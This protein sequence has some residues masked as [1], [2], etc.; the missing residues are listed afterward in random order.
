MRVLWFGS[1]WN[2]PICDPEFETDVPVGTKCMECEKVIKE[3]DRGVVTS[4]SPSIWGHWELEA[5]G[6][7]RYVCSYHLSCFLAI[8]TGGQIEG[9]RVAQRAQGV[10]TSTQDERRTEVRELE[11][12]RPGDGWE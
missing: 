1:S 11:D 7:N 12:A 10:E 6:R 4:C 8:V 2:A 9:T 3:T 5:E